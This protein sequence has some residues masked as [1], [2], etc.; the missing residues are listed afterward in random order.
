V[1]TKAIAGRLIHALRQ[2]CRR[3]LIDGK[4]EASWGA[5]VWAL[6]RSSIPV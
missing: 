2:Q 6:P 3:G 4:G 5:L 1:L